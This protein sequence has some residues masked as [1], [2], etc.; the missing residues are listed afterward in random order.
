MS[1]EHTVDKIIITNVSRLYQVNRARDLLDG[2]YNQLPRGKTF[3][4]RYLK[5]KHYSVASPK[6]WNSLPPSLR[7]CNCPDTFH[8]HFK[9]YY[10]QAFSSPMNHS[11]CASDSTIC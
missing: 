8:W 6:I 4:C 2:F 3:Y 7:C 1:L 9:T 5:L 11:T 10:L